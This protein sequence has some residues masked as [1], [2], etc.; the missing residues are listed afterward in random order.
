MKPGDTTLPAASIR[1]AAVALLSIPGGA[2]RAMRSPR[3]PRS[4]A[5]QA[6]PVPS[7]TCPLVITMS[8][9]PSGAEP[10]LVRRFCAP[11]KSDD[12]QAP[13]ISAAEPTKIAIRA[14]GRTRADLR[15]TESIGMLGQKKLYTV[16]CAPIGTI[17]ADSPQE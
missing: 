10:L 12:E 11:P 14:S 5:N 1:V 17:G 3:M 6:L 16:L 2:M 7:I 13:H 15:I 8:Y 4:A 9:A